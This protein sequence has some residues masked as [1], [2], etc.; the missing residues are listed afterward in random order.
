MSDNEL[1]GGLVEPENM[2]LMY[3]CYLCEGVAI[4]GCHVCDGTGVTAMPWSGKWITLDALIANRDLTNMW[5]F[6]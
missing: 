4:R 2:K 5:V 6:S 3:R 1:D